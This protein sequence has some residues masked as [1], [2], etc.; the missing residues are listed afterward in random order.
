MGKAF[1]EKDDVNKEKSKRGLKLASKR[2]LGVKESVDLEEGKKQE[3]NE[4]A[5]TELHLYA[6]NDS[7]LHHHS[8]LPII[9][10]LKRKVKKGTYDHEKA[11]KLWRYH[12]DRAAD[13]YKKEFG[14]GHFT[15][16]T[17]DMAAKEMRDHYDEHVRG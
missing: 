17:R 14:T 9:D 11:T 4:H 2:M 8:A 15:P 12:A 13:K 5:A 1:K 10:N 16:A 7:H 6:T 3:A